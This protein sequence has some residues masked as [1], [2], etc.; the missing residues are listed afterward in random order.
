MSL[1]S[2]R[3][4]LLLAILFLPYWIV[5]AIEPRDRADWLLEN[6]LAIVFAAVLVASF[7]RLPLSGISYTTIFLF[8]CLHTLGAHYTYA[9]VPYDDWVRA[10]TG[11]SL[12]EAMGWER[13]HFDR[14]VHFSYGLLLAYPIRE[15]FLRVVD[16]RGF[17]GY[18]LP[19]DVTMSTSMI[20]ELFEWVVAERV[21]GDLGM[22]YLGTQGD[23]WDAHKD[24]ALASLGA[25]LAMTLAMAVNVRLQRDFAREFRDSLRVKRAEPLGEVQIGRMRRGDE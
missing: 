16:A 6:L 9:E 24:M 17:W 7:K 3:Y 19:L 1:T 13:N 8:L 20:F 14:L 22:A 23:V 15:V 21:G 4:P 12:N 11:G 18:F 10:L 5:L 25:A 2:G